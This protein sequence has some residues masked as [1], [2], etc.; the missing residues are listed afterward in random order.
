F[1]IAVT[2]EDGALF[3]QATNQAKLPIFP[4][5]ETVFFLRAVDARI[6]FQ[7]DRD[8]VVTGLVLHQGGRDMPGRKIR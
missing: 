3:I 5:S 6:T 7:R 1:A 8:G 4:E 2:L